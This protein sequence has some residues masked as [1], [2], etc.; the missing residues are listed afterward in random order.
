MEEQALLSDA[1]RAA[2]VASLKAAE[3]ANLATAKALYE[4]QK[5]E[6]DEKEAR[7]RA[8]SAELLDPF[9]LGT[10]AM[11]VGAFVDNVCS[12]LYDVPLKYYLYDDLGVSVRAYY[13]LSA[14]TSIPSSLLPF[15]GLLALVPIRGCHHKFY[16]MLGYALSC[17]CYLVL[18]TSS[19]SPSFGAIVWWLTC[20]AVGSSLRST[21]L[22][23][24]MV[25]RTRHE[26]LANRGLFSLY[27]ASAS[28]CG[29]F[30]GQALASVLYENELGLGS[31]GGFTI[32]QIFVICGVV[33]LVVVIPLAC[34]LKEVPSIAA[35]STKSVAARAR[36]EFVAI[37]ETLQDKRIGCILSFGLALY[38]LTVTNAAHSY[39]L[40]DG[41]DISEPEYC[42][43]KIVQDMTLWG[44]IVFYR[45]YLFEIDLHTLFVG[46]YV[47]RTL[48]KLNDCVA[49]VAGGANSALPCLFWVGGDDVT[50]DSCDVVAAEV[51]TLALLLALAKRSARDASERS[52]SMSYLAIASILNVASSISDIID[53][54]LEDIWD[55]NT[56]KLEAHDYGGYWRLELLT[57]LVPLAVLG[58]L[59]LLPRTREAAATKEDGWFAPWKD[60]GHGRT[61]A[62]LFVAFWVLG[63]VYVFVYSIET[64]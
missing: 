4:Q 6:G 31:W 61:A 15:F 18:G 42:W 7:G 45:Q 49:V 3:A 64:A 46:A 39:L 25:E 48:A 55:V 44:V 27:L 51:L 14:C 53:I 38:L 17:A 35:R 20:A 26:T 41:C 11:L 29:A 22:A 37:W 9:A 59:P 10:V 24:M 60:A 5:M 62:F 50:Y 13:V 47:V 43:L 32:S 23:M 33:P 36:F 40:L 34:F 56:D 2:E 52:A 19:G 63:D 16:W 12:A 1:D 8:E 57:A 28:Y 58:F 30:V 21:M 54:Y